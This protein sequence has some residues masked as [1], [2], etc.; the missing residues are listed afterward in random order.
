MLTEG[1]ASLHF[2][3]ANLLNADITVTDLDVVII[4]A[5]G[6]TIDLSMFSMKFNPI[7]CEEIALAECMQL[8][9]TA[10]ILIHLHLLFRS[11]SRFGLCYSLG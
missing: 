2:C 7:S 4:D 3:I 9:T 6:R 10:E 5:G 8:S 1:K 11:T